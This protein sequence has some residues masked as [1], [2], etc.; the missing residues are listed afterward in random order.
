MSRV[1][2]RS[3]HNH[4]STRRTRTKSKAKLMSLSHLLGCWH[5][6]EGEAIALCQ[7][8]R[9]VNDNC[10]Q[11][12]QKEFSRKYLYSYK[13]WILSWSERHW[14]SMRRHQLRPFCNR[15][16]RRGLPKIIEGLN[17]LRQE[18]ERHQRRPHYH[19]CVSCQSYPQILL[20]RSIRSSIETTVKQSWITNHQTHGKERIESFRTWKIREAG[21]SCW[22]SIRTSSG[23]S[24]RNI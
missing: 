6:I 15:D 24:R 23:L 10:Q 13:A 11:F 16:Q 5:W 4:T 7:S 21:I 1:Q 8:S 12:S 22:A 9:P 2:S 18:W 3:Q 17:L 14:K 20:Y 19:N